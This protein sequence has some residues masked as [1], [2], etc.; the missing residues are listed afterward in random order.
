MWVSKEVEHGIDV[1][2]GDET[3]TKWINR[4]ITELTIRQLL[5]RRLPFSD[6]ELE[7]ARRR[8]QERGIMIPE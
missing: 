3:R 4:A 8:G 1:L 2:R 7:E 6:E 5:E